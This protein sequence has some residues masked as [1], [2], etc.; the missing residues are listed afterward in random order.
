MNCKKCMFFQKNNFEGT[1]LRYKMFGVRG[2]C[3][4]SENPDFN[5]FAKAAGR[6]LC[7]KDIRK[8]P[9]WCRFNK[10]E[11]NKTREAG[12]ALENYLLYEVSVYKY[13]LLQAKQALDYCKISACEPAKG[14]AE[15]AIK[16]IGD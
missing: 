10:K 14:V 13:L 7:R 6:G 15:V 5:D 4:D 1:S 2:F 11:S 3:M 16:I 12:I 8:S 9:D